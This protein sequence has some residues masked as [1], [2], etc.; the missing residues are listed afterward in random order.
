MIWPALIGAGVSIVGGMM[1]KKNADKNAKNAQFKP[2]NSTGDLGEAIISKGNR[3]GD[4]AV[5]RNRDTTASGEARDFFE[6]EFNR[7]A[8]DETGRGQFGTDTLQ[9][10]QNLFN[11]ALNEALGAGFDQSNA[12]TGDFL[13]RN[14]QQA[15]SLGSQGNRG[16]N[17]LF[18]GPSAAGNARTAGG[19]AQSLLNSGL[20]FNQLA[21]DRTAQLTDLARPGEETATNQKFQSL[22]GSGRLGTT[23]GAQ[24]LGQLQQ[25]QQRAATE[26]GIAGMT[27]AQQQQQQQLQQAQGFLG[28]GN[29]AIG[30]DLPASVVLQIT[31]T[32]PAV[33]GSTAAG[34]TKPATLSSGIEIQVPEYL[35]PGEKVKVSTNNAKFVSRAN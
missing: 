21:A 5:I 33:K 13:A 2:F 20:D 27:F 15:D 29:Q 19:A 17:S 14:R 8:A 10:G 6:G 4:S 32:A 11:P 30:L 35:A 31:D 34:R 7:F 28:A 24:A 1:K 26:R 3:P 25:A 23:G 16:V 18:N 22:F 12:A 9:Q